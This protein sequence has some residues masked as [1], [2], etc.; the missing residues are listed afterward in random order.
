MKKTDADRPTYAIESVDNALRLLLLI[1]RDGQLRVS[2]AS[3]ALGVAVSTAHR[4]LAM[5]QY[6]GFVRQDPDSRIY[7]AGPTLIRLG[8]TAVRG[9]DLRTVA[10]PFIEALRDET[11]ET[12]HVA[13]LRG[14][15]VLFVDSVEGLNALRVASRVGSTMWAHCTSVGKALLASLPENDLLA[16]YPNKTLPGITEHSITS[17]DALLEELKRVRAKGYA[18]STG[19]SEEGVGSVGVVIHGPNRPLIGAISAA[20]PLLRA[21]RH[22]V[23][24]I[25]KSVKHTADAIAAELDG[26]P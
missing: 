25:A 23:V 13:V 6:H 15:E 2:E 3:E 1:E 22:R 18:W 24:E 26:T 11:R 10:R 19:E 9:M 4:L 20:Y 5:L 16:R 12:V 14:Q 7:L 21:S 17:R 8:L